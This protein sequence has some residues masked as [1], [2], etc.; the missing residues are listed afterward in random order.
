MKKFFKV[1]LKVL[2]VI[3][4][5]WV[6]IIFSF[7]FIRK[8]K[9]HRFMKNLGGGV[10]FA[11]AKQ[12][13]AEWKETPSDIAGMTL[14]DKYKKGLA[15]NNGSDTDGD[16]LTDKEEIEVY[17]SDPLKPSTS[18]DLYSDAYKV[19][20]GMDLNEYYEYDSPQEY[21]Y[22]ECPE[23]ILDAVLPTDFNAVVTVEEGSTGLG[24][25]SLYKQYRVYNYGGKLGFNVA[26]IL[27][28][29]EIKAKDI[30]IYVSDG[31]KTKNYSFE[32]NGNIITT[33]KNL[34][35]DREYIV[36]LVKAGF[37]T[38]SSIMF[39]SV[40]PLQTKDK[41]VTGEGLFFGSIIWY[42][43]THQPF[44][45]YYE[46][47]LKDEDT[48]ALKAK[49]I[50]FFDGDEILSEETMV[51]KPGLEIKGG[52]EVLKTVLPI[53][54][55]TQYATNL[56][57]IHW[58]QWIFCY[59]SYKDAAAKILEKEFLESM[60]FS[61][62][63][64][65]IKDELPFANFKSDIGTTGNCAGI[66]HL[67][68]VLYNTGKYESSGRYFYKKTGADIMWNIS[69]DKANNT[70]TNKELYD[71]K[72]AEF[73]PS[74]SKKQKDETETLSAGEKE[75]VK[76]IGVAYLQGNEKA[77]Y[78]YSTLMGGE[79]SKV[80]YDYSLI[81][82]MMSRLDKGKILD[83]YFM[84]NDKTGH[85]MNIIGYRKDEN[86][87]NVVRFDVYDSN[88]PHALLDDYKLSEEGLT[89]VVTKKKKKD[90]SGSTFSYEYKPLSN[91]NYGTT[92][93]K[94]KLKN[95]CMI[96]MDENWH[97]LND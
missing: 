19:E 68:A 80:E 40:N 23:V 47:K 12:N 89:L 39:G 64:N 96:V 78:I 60:T 1:L 37:K 95:P 4:L 38:S 76:M 51:K 32:T 92:S 26:D 53:F 6:V 52:Y 65:G 63:F 57:D 83:A 54:D 27:S 5:I 7:V 36:M 18:G 44:N 56:D 86:D 30:D 87:P 45:L 62:G 93:N 94:A 75:F 21:P 79:N 61:S 66:S 49:M 2:I 43:F 84:M 73:K 70:L 29:E 20:N 90:G 28:K 58:Y 8:Y 15:V 22:N 69:T 97:L 71:Y 24:A 91:S 42:A 77:N 46:Q 67:T 14:W 55:I 25:D 13:E 81:E 33:K 59:I 82:A 10:E 74:P 50:E 35:S 16:G 31:N 48:E 88:I 9:D 11:T 17:G 41:E 34:D 85:S 72:T 3:I